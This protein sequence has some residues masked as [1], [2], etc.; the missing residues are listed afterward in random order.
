MGYKS[1]TQIILFITSLV[2]IFT[3]IQPSFITIKDEQ[4]ELFEYADASNKASELNVRL[5]ELLGVEQSFSNADIDALQGYLPSS[6]DEMSVMSDIVTIAEKTGSQVTSLTASKQNEPEGD[7]T[8]AGERI[9]SDGTSY[10]DFTL[11][12]NADYDSFKAMLALLEQNKYPLE[13]VHLTVGDFLVEDDTVVTSVDL[14]E[15]IYNIVLRTYAYS[16]INN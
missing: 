8:F 4:D 12:I 5:A 2:I 1:I 6:V 16:P 9:T 11:T 10:V 15:G 3:Y 13:I 7:I 14:I